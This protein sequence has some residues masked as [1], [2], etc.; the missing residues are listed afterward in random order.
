MQCK[1]E[2]EELT[3]FLG[4]EYE[5][6]DWREV[7]KKCLHMY[8]SYMCCL[9]LKVKTWIQ[10]NYNQTAMVY[11]VINKCLFLYVSCHC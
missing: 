2:T 1:Q 8:V 11:L 3:E 10:F 9:H 5:L 6:D 7:I 4:L